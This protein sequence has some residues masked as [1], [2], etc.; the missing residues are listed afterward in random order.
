MAHL[1]IVVLQQMFDRG[2]RCSDG[3]GLPLGRADYLRLVGLITH[4]QGLA[5]DGFGRTQDEVI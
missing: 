4:G 2:C 1:T 3:L 5:N